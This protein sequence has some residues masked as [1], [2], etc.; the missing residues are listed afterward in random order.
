MSLLI[1]E[2]KCVFLV[3][4]ELHFPISP[5]KEFQSRQ[6]LNDLYFKHVIKPILGGLGKIA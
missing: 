3:K 4:V 2:R 5:S 1:R 6:F